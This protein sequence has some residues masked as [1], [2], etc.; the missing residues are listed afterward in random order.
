M[1]RPRARNRGYRSFLWTL[2]RRGLHEEA[3]ASGSA[4][5]LL[6]EVTV[7]VSDVGQLA[8]AVFVPYAAPPTCAPCGASSNVS[9]LRV[10][11]P[12]AT[13]PLLFV[14]PSRFVPPFTEH[15]SDLVYSV[16]RL[17]SMVNAAKVDLESFKA[18][19]ARH[20]QT[21]NSNR[22]RVTFWAVT[23]CLLV[24]AVAVAQVVRIRN[25]F[26]FKRIV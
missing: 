12:L 2:W 11:P 23:E 15:V 9:P 18:R 19:E 20:R 8:H 4:R 5:H 16:E 17:N 13:V 22:R 25:F 24:L 21:A 3:S 1:A 26:E 6:D 7:C 10:P 14:L